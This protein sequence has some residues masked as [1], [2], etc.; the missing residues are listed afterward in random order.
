MSTIINIYLI[1]ALI[2][3]IAGIGFGVTGAFQAKAENGRVPQSDARLILA[4]IIGVPLL[5]PLWGPVLVL[6]GGGYALRGLYR[7]TQDAHVVDGLI[8]FTEFRTSQKKIME[9]Q[10]REL[11]ASNR[12]MEAELEEREL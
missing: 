1:I 8:N 7:V 9:G 11:T 12:R 3:A 5:A 6:G 2:I 4:L 10:I